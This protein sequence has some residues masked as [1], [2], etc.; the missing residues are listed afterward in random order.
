MTTGVKLQ[1]LMGLALNMLRQQSG[2]AGV[3][4]LSIYHLLDPPGERNWEIADVNAGNCFQGDVNRGVITVHYQL[5]R[6]FR[7]L[8][9]D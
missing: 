1:E 3:G 6:S 7:L 2:C 9:D 8:E 4:G 5:S